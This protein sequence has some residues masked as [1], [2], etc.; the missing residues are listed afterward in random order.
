MLT[1]INT[2]KSFCVGTDDESIWE[3]DGVAG[4]SGAGVDDTDVM[5]TSFRELRAI[6]EEYHW[7]TADGVLTV[8]DCPMTMVALV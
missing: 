6:A 2:G 7:Y 8:E 3:G 4:G 5:A 1:L